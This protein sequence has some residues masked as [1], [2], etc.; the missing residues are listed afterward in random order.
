M[1]KLFEENELNE[2]PFGYRFI[3]DDAYAIYKT[4]E[5]TKKISSEY[6]QT[7]DKEILRGINKPISKLFNS[8]EIF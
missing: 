1:G 7:N 4:G 3:N 5:K 2:L 8:D 6:Y